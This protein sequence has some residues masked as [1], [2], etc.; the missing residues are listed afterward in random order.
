MKR[1]I[2]QEEPDKS[3]KRGKLDKQ[4]SKGASSKDEICATPKTVR[5]QSLI[6]LHSSFMRIFRLCIVFIKIAQF[7]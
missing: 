5:L 6:Y 4:D 1:K 3:G 2:S 7:K